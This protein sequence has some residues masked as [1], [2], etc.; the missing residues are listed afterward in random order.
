M[1]FK[2]SIC[3]KYRT[4]TQVFKCGQP[5]CP[6]S[7]LFELLFP[8]SR[9]SSAQSN[10]TSSWYVTKRNSPHRLSQTIMHERAWRWL[11]LVYNGVIIYYFS[12]PTLLPFAITQQI[13]VC[14]E[15]LFCDSLTITSSI[16]FLLSLSSPLFSVYSPLLFT[17]APALL[18]PSTNATSRSNCRRP[19]KNYIVNYIY[20]FSLGLNRNKKKYIALRIV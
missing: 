15:L 18:P 13:Y 10:L 19:L 5:H 8:G 3:T 12:C 6:I 14:P 4:L 7:G 11:R 1:T 20:L 16:K 9:L 17:R 2:E